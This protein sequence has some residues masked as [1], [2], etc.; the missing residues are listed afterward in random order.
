MNVSPVFDIKNAPNGS[1]GNRCIVP[2]VRRHIVCKVV[3]LGLAKAESVKGQR[4]CCT[5]EELVYP[6]TSQVPRNLI[7]QYDVKERRWV[8]DI[9]R[10]SVPARLDASLFATVQQ[11]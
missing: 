7:L 9:R 11:Q 3:R 8:A 6:G 2:A 1:K 5:M 10:N 4:C